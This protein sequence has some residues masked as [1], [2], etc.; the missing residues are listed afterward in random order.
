L[1]AGSHRSRRRAI[2]GAN[3]QA[4]QDG[5]GSALKAK[6]EPKYR[7][8]RLLIFAGRARID[9]IDFDFAEAVTPAIEAHA[10]AWRGI[11]QAIYV[12]DSQEG[13]LVELTLG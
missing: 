9:L 8:L 10:A 4:W 2:S 12:V 5:I 3:L 11:F 6:L 13:A 7:G 1:V